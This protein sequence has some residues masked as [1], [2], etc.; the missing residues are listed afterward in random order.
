M[1]VQNRGYISQGY[2][3]NKNK[4]LISE[5]Y[6]EKTHDKGNATHQTGF[7]CITVFNTGCSISYKGESGKL[8]VHIL[9]K[10]RPLLQSP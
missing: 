3:S 1:P 2:L 6:Y 10:I 4:S 5:I 8:N 9:M 7:S